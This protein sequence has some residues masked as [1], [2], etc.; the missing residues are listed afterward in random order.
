M[1]NTMTPYKKPSNW[2][3]LRGPK[4]GFIPTFPTEHQ[5]VVLKCGYGT[6]ENGLPFLVGFPLKPLNKD[7]DS[8]EN[9]YD[10]EMLNGV[11]FL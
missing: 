4:P 8:S 1:G 9:C 2:F 7:T 10:P 5:Q 11:A 6:P 3:P